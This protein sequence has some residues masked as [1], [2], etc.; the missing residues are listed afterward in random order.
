MIRLAC[1]A[2]PSDAIPRI[3]NRGFF[4]RSLD[5]APNLIKAPG[6]S[7]VLVAVGVEMVQDFG[8]W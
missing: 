7:R 6:A 3:I 5:L 4:F 1:K 2:S 8:A